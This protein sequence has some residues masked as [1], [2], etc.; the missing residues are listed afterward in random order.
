M[1]PLRKRI[2]STAAIASL[3]VFAA[4]GPASAAAVTAER[5]KLGLTALA[6]S[7]DSVDATAE[8]PSGRT[9]DLTWTVSDPD[10]A[11]TD[12]HG[13]VE[14]RLFNGDVA[15]GPAR[16]YNWR[17]QPGGT[18]DVVADS[19]ATAQL[20]SYTLH[21]V[22]PQY[23]PAAQVTWRVVKVTAA[24]DLGNTRSYG[25]DKLAAFDST[26]AVT[27]LVDTEAPVLQLFGRSWEQ[28]P[29]LYTDGRQLTFKYTAY[30]LDQQSGFWK[31]KVKLRGP[32]DTRVVWPI[33]LVKVDSSTS[34]CGDFPNS[35][36]SM[37]WC[38]LSFTL[39]QGSP[40]GVW[41]VTGVELTD[42][43]GNSATREVDAET[44]DV[45]TTSN[46]PLSASGFALSATE[47]DNWRED[48]PVRLSLLPAGAQGAVTSVRVHSEC[49]Q[50]D[51]TPM[52]A[53]D[54]IVSVELTV[55]ASYSGCNVS[56]IEVQDAA[57]NL[58]LYGTEFGNS[59]LG[60]RVSQ[61]ADTTAPVVVSVVLSRTSGTPNEM[62]N[63]RA[64]V[65]LA[66]SEQSRIGLYNFQFFNAQGVGVG[67]NSSWAQQNDDGTITVE[68]WLGTQSPGV[69]TGGFELNDEAGNRAAYGYGFA[70]AL[71]MP[72]GPLVVTVTEG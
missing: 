67:G 43:A 16:S 50:L 51:T 7:A 13:T 33:Q 23:G 12:V 17:S 54:G 25:T 18:A 45:H 53:A 46:S 49:W 68:T 6:F 31:G 10:A 71:P 63:I 64:T 1:T 40:A 69:Y 61:V 21:F 44:S 59:D 56:G 52:V 36:D 11:A 9:V 38:E 29:E 3:A 57:G 58:A 42:L 8:S 41:H 22:V 37:V 66:P 65:T 2:L 55:P 15:V 32:G 70:G 27:E 62:T 60:L 34:L 48:K 14:L 28:R 30:F 47:V 26:V 39:P 35:D 5:A 19:P 24:D 4:A 20:S 72:G